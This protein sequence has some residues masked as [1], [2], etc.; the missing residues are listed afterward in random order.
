MN[1]EVL[2]D[3]VKTWF[4]ERMF[5][6]VT[7]GQILQNSN[8]SLLQRRDQIKTLYQE[9]YRETPRLYYGDAAQITEEIRHMTGDIDDEVRVVIIGG[10]RSPRVWSEILAQRL[11]RLKTDGKAPTFT[12]IMV[13]EPNDHQTNL[14]KINDEISD[15]Y[16]VHKEYEVEDCIKLY[17]LEATPPIVFDLILIDKK[18]TLIGIPVREE[19][20]ERL[21]K[22]VILRNQPEITG[23]YV[24]WFDRYLLKQDVI[25]YDKWRILHG[26][27]HEAPLDNSQK[28]SD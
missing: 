9:I 28:P 20:E 23:S 16:A 24:S 27:N 8:R 12:T 15:R 3:I 17:I 2:F 18:H 5:H 1:H 25:E 19:K 11:S 7:H 22:A 26:L 21:H 14:E 10:V 4:D 13:V 6:G